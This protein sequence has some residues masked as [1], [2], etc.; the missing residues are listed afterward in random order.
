MLRRNLS[1]LQS[2]PGTATPTKP[3]VSIPTFSP[4]MFALSA[5]DASALDHHVEQGLLLRRRG[6]RNGD[7]R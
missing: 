7:A 6:Y 1:E 5:S 2:F 4:A 3:H